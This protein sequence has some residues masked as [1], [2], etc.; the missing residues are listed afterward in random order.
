[1]KLPQLSL[2]DLFC[3]MALTLIGLAVGGQ[4]HTALGDEALGD[5]KAVQHPVDP[6]LKMARDAQHR[7][8]HGVSDY[9]CV[10]RKQERVADVL[11]DEQA[12]LMK[13]RLRRECEGKVLTPAGVYLRFLA[14]A[15]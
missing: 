11:Q 2:R 14:P 13:V 6:V 15:S 7:L 1:M 12:A 5:S 3:P 4:L 8:Q 10:L 9:Q